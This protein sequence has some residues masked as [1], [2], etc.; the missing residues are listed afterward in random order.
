MSITYAREGFVIKRCERIEGYFRYKL[1][2]IILALW[3]SMPAVLQSQND[4]LFKDIC[5]LENGEGQTIDDRGEEDI[6]EFNLRENDYQN[7]FEALLNQPD[8]WL[9]REFIN[10]VRFQE[11]IT[12]LAL[13]YK[14][15]RDIKPPDHRTMNLW[16]HELTQDYPVCAAIAP[17]FARFLR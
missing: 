2:F 3:T 4:N 16:I 13:R 6:F 8:S 9:A 11:E 5:E 1:C 12:G 17:I 14:S 7:H 10:D 15:K